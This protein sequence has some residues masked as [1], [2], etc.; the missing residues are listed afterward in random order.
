M[1]R[2]IF[3]VL[4]FFSFAISTAHASPDP[5]SYDQMVQAKTMIQILKLPVPPDSIRQ[6]LLKEAR[7]EDLAFVK[8]MLVHWKSNSSQDLS[9]E[10]NHVILRNQSGAEIMHM[11]P[12]ENSPGKFEINGRVWS[13]P[14]KGSVAASLNKHLAKKL[15]AASIFDIVGRAYAAG[16]YSPN[17][18]PAIYYYMATA[19]PTLGD[20]A[21]LHLKMF[22]ASK[23]FSLQDNFF[24]DLFGSTPAVTCG[25]KEASGRLVIGLEAMTFRVREDGNVM[26]TSFNSKKTF[27]ANNDDPA[28]WR[29]GVKYQECSDAACSSTVGPQKNRITSFLKLKSPVPVDVAYTFRPHDGNQNRYPV[30]FDCPDRNECDRMIIKDIENMSTVDRKAAER[31]VVAANEALAKSKAEQNEAIQ[32]IR[33]LFACCQNEKCRKEV[34]QVGIRMDTAPTHGGPTSH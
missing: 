9:A 1:M 29:S 31:V 7:P 8:S 18:R 6:T 27:V 19:K 10:F 17:V 4:F 22:E 11:V 15:D 21:A 2:A 12:I 32:A 3:S 16:E 26:L 23:H 20:M 28:H 13:A 14:E 34:L 24:Q 5:A 30:T 25:A 33:P